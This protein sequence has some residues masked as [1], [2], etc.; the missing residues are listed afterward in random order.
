MRERRRTVTPESS[1]GS[2]LY[3]NKRNGRGE[4]DEGPCTLTFV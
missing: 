3:I 4:W 2:L 1:P